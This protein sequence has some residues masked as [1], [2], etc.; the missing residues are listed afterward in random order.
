MPMQPQVSFI[1]LGSIF[2]ELGC[3]LLVLQIPRL[4]VLFMTSV[5]IYAY[6]RSSHHLVAFKGDTIIVNANMS[7]LGDV[8]PPSTSTTNNV[9]LG[10]DNAPTQ[11]VTHY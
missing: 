10:D 6:R 8:T 11:K 1:F 2:F 5:S 4:F 9:L 7:P 3:C